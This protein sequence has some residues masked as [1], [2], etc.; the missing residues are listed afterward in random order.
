M[1]IKSLHYATVNGSSQR[2]YLNATAISR[3]LNGYHLR[4]SPDQLKGIVPAQR[5]FSLMWSILNL[6]QT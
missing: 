5:E 6:L 1:F 4:Q 2:C 3:L